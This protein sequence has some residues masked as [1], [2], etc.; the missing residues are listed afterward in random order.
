M[1][2]FTSKNEA[3]PS[4]KHS[5]VGWAMP[6]AEPRSLGLLTHG[7]LFLRM[8]LTSPGTGKG[9]HHSPYLYLS[10]T[11]S[12]MWYSISQELAAA[13]SL[14]TGAQ[15]FSLRSSLVEG[16]GFAQ[17]SALWGKQTEQNIGK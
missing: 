12:V 17:D 5:L 11:L 2:P 16:W 10:S 7:L 9:F 3:K 15:C 4:S 1:S 8:S 6:A 14:H 13:T